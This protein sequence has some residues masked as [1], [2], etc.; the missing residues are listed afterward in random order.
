[1]CGGLHVVSDVEPER[2]P[3]AT[4]SPTAVAAEH[5]TQIS[6]EAVSIKFGVVAIQHSRAIQVVE[7]VT[8]ETWSLC[9]RIS[10]IHDTTLLIQLDYV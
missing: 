3:I 8:M 4:L 10:T 7:V 6:G 2:L 9:S 5:V 1:M